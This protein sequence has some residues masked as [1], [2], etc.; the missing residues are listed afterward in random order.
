[1]FVAFALV[2]LCTMLGLAGSYGRMLAKVE[3]FNELMRQKDALA[4]QLSSARQDVEQTRAEVASLGSLATQ[5]SA[6]YNLGRKNSLQDKLREVSAQPPADDYQ[7]NL[8]AFQTL[9]AEALD[10]RVLGR[11]SL[12]NADWRPSLWPVSGRVSSGFGRRLDPFD[13][14]GGFH[15][16]LDIATNYGT[17]IRVTAD[18]VV[19]FC[20]FQNGYGRTVIVNHG[21]G[22]ETL[23]AHLAGFGTAVGDHVL[24]GDLIGFVGRSGRTTGSHLHYEVRINNA[25]V[26]PHR[27]LRG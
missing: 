26:N 13:G 20:G 5:I 7:S 12:L 27:F 19:V 2:G 22:I 17:P 23:Y 16:G 14:E 25:P 1:M 24:R 9:E 18:G 15:S 6:I 21:H 4:H 10:T 8:A 11:W 3:H